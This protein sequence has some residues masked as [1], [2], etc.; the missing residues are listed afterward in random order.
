MF[1]G[2]KQDNVEFR[3]FSNVKRYCQFVQ[4]NAE[5]AKSRAEKT[6]LN[7][8]KAESKAE[9]ADIAEYRSYLI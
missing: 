8:D 1:S 9:K 6:E 7:A 4:S 2:R 5:K 3:T